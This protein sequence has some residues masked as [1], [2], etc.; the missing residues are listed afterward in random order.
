MGRTNAQWFDEL[1]EMI[2]EIKE[3]GQEV[4]DDLAKEAIEFV[5]LMTKTNDPAVIVPIG[6]TLF[7]KLGKLLWDA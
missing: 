4:P 7:K 2:A 1:W 3:R 6:D 5:E